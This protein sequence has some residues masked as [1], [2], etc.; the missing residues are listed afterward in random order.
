MKGRCDVEGCREAASWRQYE[1]VDPSLPV[2]LCTPHWN[3]TRILDLNSSLRYGPSRL[4]YD[5]TDRS[6]EQSDSP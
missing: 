6:R 2:Y 4:F 3:E 5:R 1:P